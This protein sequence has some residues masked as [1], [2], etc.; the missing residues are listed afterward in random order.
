[1]HGTPDFTQTY[2]CGPPLTRLKNASAIA[3]SDGIEMLLFISQ[4]VNQV[5]HNYLQL[6]MKHSAI[7][8]EVF[9]T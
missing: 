3:I 1:M 4:A 2:P 9:L 6:F 5:E 7:Q 8:Q